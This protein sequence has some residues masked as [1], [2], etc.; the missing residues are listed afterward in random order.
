MCISLW[1][2]IARSFSMASRNI[3]IIEKYFYKCSIWILKFKNNFAII[4]SFGGWFSVCVCMCVCS[5]C[6]S[7]YIVLWF[8]EGKAYFKIVMQ[9]TMALN[10]WISCI[11]CSNTE[12]IGMCHHNLLHLWTPSL[13]LKFMTSIYLLLLLCT[14]IYV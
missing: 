4:L 3:Y 2:I 11:F 1:L 9:Q 5:L 8:E 6:L 12:I 10:I 14:S 7:L 13:P